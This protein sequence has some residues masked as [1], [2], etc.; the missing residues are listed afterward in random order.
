[1]PI[2]HNDTTVQNRAENQITKFSKRL[3]ENR[4]YLAEVHSDPDYQKWLN[5][6][7]HPLYAKAIL[8]N[9]KQASEL[10]FSDEFVMS[11]NDRK[12]RTV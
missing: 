11:Q 10:L 4:N 1:M 12:N 7:K 8:S 5:E 6:N 9:T 2:Y 3:T